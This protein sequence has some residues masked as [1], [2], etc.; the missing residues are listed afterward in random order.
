MLLVLKPLLGYPNK[1]WCY[2]L[3]FSRIELKKIAPSYPRGYLLKL[4]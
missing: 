4:C 1:M 3:T 2:G